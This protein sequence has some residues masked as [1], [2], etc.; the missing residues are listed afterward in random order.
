MFLVS[1]YLLCFDRKN[2]STENNM[3]KKQIVDINEMNYQNL[4]ILL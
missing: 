2:N 3:E 1:L 4:S